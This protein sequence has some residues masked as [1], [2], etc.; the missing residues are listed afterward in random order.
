MKERLLQYLVC[1]ECRGELSLINPQ[2]QAGEIWEAELNC[3]ACQHS[4]KVADGIP[5]FV[6]SIMDSVVQRNVE[7]FGAQWHLLGERSEL[8]RR[9][10]LSYLDKVSPDFFKGKLVLDAGCGM[11]KFLYYAAE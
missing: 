5:R 6:P 1:P 10:F 4:Y 2:Y 9:E 7:N 3:V 11:G 8:N